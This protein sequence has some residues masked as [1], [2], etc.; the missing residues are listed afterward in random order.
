TPAQHHDG[1]DASILQHRKQVY[2]AAKQRHPER[3]SGTT[4]DWELKGEVWLNP[5]RNQYEELRKVA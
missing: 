5:E 3:W 2:E 4:R 1:R